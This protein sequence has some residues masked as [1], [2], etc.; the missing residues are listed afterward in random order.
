[1][2]EAQAVKALG[3]IEA[4]PT[5]TRERGDKLGQPVGEEARDYLD[6]LIGGKAVR[7]DT[8]EADK[9]MQALAVIPDGRLIVTS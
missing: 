3:A 5:V 1:M 8:Y 7:V 2:D 6:H 4:Q 9:S